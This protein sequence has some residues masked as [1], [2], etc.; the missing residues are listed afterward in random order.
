MTSFGSWYEQQQRS[1]EN[2]DHTTT[3][4]STSNNNG[5]TE[6]NS[7]LFFSSFGMDS[8]QVLP[9][10]NSESLSGFSLES[11]RQSMEAQMPKKILGMG[12]Q[13]RF[14][15]SQ[16]TEIG[17]SYLCV[18]HYDGIVSFF[19]FLSHAHTCGLLFPCPFVRYFV[20]CSSYQHYSFPWP[21]S[22]VFPF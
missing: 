19:F 21:F 1:S 6:G 18:V 3:T 11:M 10:F 17:K 20:P 4:I 5:T 9:L 15:V 22:L 16:P 12:Y 8:E 7:S 2:G 14:K 13:Q